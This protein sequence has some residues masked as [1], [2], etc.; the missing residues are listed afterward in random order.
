MNQNDQI[1]DSE[2]PKLKRS[3]TGN[4]PVYNT[5]HVEIVEPFIYLCKFLE[6]S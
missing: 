5:K 2:F 6:I 1:T 4:Y 3:V